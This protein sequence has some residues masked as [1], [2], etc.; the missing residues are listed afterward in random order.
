VFVW[1]SNNILHFMTNLVQNVGLMVGV[2][3][4]CGWRGVCNKW[5]F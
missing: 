5:C 3:D 2:W 1:S 4:C